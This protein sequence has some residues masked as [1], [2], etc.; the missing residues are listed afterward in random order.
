MTRDE[1]REAV[2]VRDGGQC[3]ICKAPAK[4]AH[5]IL[6]RRLFADG[7]YHPDNGVA[8]CAVHHLKAEQTRLSPEELREAAGITHVHL[9]DHLYPDEHY[10]KWGNQVISGGRRLRGELFFD[11]SVQNALREGAVLHLF[12]PWVK[13]PRTHH[14]SWSPGIHADDRIIPSL[15]RL[16]GADEVVATVKMDGENTSLYRDN[17]HARS[18]ESEDH[19]SR[20]WIK[21]LWSRIRWDIP[22]GWRVC[23]ENLW[24][25]HSIRYTALPSYFLG[26]SV[27]D[28]Q[29]VCLSWSSTVEWLDLLGIPDHVEVFYR[30]RFDHQAIQAAFEQG[31]GKD[32]EHCEGYVVRDA[33][34]FSYRDFRHCV[35]KWVRPGHVQ[36]TKHWFR[37]QIVVPNKL[38]G[39]D[40][41]GS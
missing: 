34:T 39:K 15:V 27:W 3:V 23:G 38:G 33:G 25:Q 14:L 30:D 7:G 32:L 20:H 5:H 31:P 11:G 16:E 24:A 26:F 22:D 41:Q 13:Y 40:D 37:G 10:D 8:V 6:E 18:L 36:T 4:D 12:T 1:F 35:A 29:N 21:N 28:K 17:V 2:F 19:I 9:P